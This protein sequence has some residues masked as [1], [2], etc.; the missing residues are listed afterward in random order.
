[1]M[2]RNLSERLLDMVERDRRFVGLPDSAVLL[3]IKLMRLYGRGELPACTDA[4]LSNACS[5]EEV[6]HFLRLRR[7]AYEVSWDLGLL[8]KQ[9]LLVKIDNKFCAPPEIA[10]LDSAP[11]ITIVQ[12]S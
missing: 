1:M 2:A 7:A 12:Q 9:Q 4:D 3:W 8:V 11:L 6:A 10:H 5:E